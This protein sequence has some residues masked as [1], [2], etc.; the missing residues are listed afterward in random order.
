MTCQNV[1]F[2]YISNYSTL[3]APVFPGFAAPSTKRFC[4][5]PSANSSL[6]SCR[7]VE[8]GCVMLLILNLRNSANLTTLKLLILFSIQ[9]HSCQ[10]ACR[11]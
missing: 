4:E 11:V 2:V 10:A 1:V 6:S 8:R 9:V 3:V 7:R 5:S